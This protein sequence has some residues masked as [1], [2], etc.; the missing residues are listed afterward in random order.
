M[1]LC[2]GPSGSGKTVL[3]KTLQEDIYSDVE[4]L[5]STIPTVG[6]N[7][8]NVKTNN[9]N[10]VTVHELGGEMAPI[11]DNHLNSCQH[12]LYVIDISNLQQVSCACILLLE[13]L[14]KLELENMRVLIVLNK[15]DAMNTLTMNE[16]KGLLRLDDISKYA[17]QRIDVVETSCVLGEGLE[18]IRDW[19]SQVNAS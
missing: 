17:K 8:I 2:L 7:I 15:T 13:I 14:S 9:N 19:L 3:L 12:L 11:W 18:F 1:I 5:P 4:E 10:S 6:T 16:M